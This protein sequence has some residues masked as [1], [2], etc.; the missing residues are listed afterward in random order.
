[1][2]TR[3]ELLKRV[4]GFRAMGTSRRPG[5]G[6]LRVGPLEVDRSL[7]RFAFEVSR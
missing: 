3:D 6:K 1:M 4:W 7:G 2:L 5:S